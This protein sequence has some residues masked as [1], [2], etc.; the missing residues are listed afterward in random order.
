MPWDHVNNLFLVKLQPFF[1]LKK[2]GQFTEYSGQKGSDTNLQSL[3]ISCPW[4]QGRSFS[5]PRFFPF[6]SQLVPAG[7]L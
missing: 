2:R 7:S 4:W 5:L 1:F 3:L 6:E